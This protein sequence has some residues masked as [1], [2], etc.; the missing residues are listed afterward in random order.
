MLDKIC[1]L[2]W[3]YGSEEMKSL[4]KAESIV[5]R[6]VAVEK[7]L[8]YGLAKAGIAPNECVNVVEVCS[9]NV[10]A[11][12]VYAKEKEL[13]HDIASLAYLLGEKC[14][15]CGKYI[16]LGATSYDVVDT[17]WALIIN[18]ALSIVMKK[19]KKIIEVLSDMA[20]KHRKTLMVGRTH[21][22]HALPITFGFKLANYVYEFARSY[23]RLCECR[24][25]IVKGKI[26]GAVGTMAAWGSRGLFVE[27]YAMEYL[28]LEPHAISTQVAPRDGFAE[29][30]A[31]LAILGSQLD[32][33]A[34]EVRELSR[35]EIGEVYESAKRV[36]S[37]TMPHKRNP[38][39]AERISGLA[40]ILRSMVMVALENIPLMHERD[41][42]NSSSERI[43]IP[44]VFLVADQMLIDMEKLLSVLYVDEEAMKRNLGLGKGAIMA[45]AVMV[46][47]VEK[48]IPRHLAHKKLQEIA[49]AVG[50]DEDF[51]EKLLK[52]EEIS[53][54]FT[55]EELK[56]IIDYDNYVGQSENL[57]ERSI[58]Y[59]KT[60]LSSCR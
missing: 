47:L 1:V 33:F 30:V 6:Y 50:G 55:H 9:E 12:E 22:Q 14:G 41:L 13:G 2:D 29:L 53:K 35:P 17:V 31:N 32:R 18:E 43:L 37:S 49:I 21:G 57:I 26:S 56:N 45:E 51:L 11:E 44:H 39:I 36:G 42:T 20:V 15:E 52:D 19:L 16:H 8:I 60:V 59:A 25:R 48:G 24:K 5:K 7:A 40:K 46:K 3:R 34:L 58:A 4:F 23:E 10:S 27:K 38:V 54:L 28:D